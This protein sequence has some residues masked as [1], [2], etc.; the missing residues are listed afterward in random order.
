MDATEAEMIAE[1][2][3]RAI[4]EVTPEGQAF[5][6]DAA[7]R[8]EG[9]SGPLA[10]S[11]GSFAEYYERWSKPWEHQALIKA[12]VGAGSRELGDRFLELAR[13]FAFPQELHPDSLAEM[14]HLKARMERER[15]TRGTDPRRNLKLGPGGLSDIEFA[16]QLLQLQHGRRHEEL[17]ATNTL[18]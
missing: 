9:K 7:L 15:I 13:R 12:R 16:V 2:L 14:R 4:G 17:R 8:P 1:E 6:I 10:R 3:M 5:R 18:D 11:V